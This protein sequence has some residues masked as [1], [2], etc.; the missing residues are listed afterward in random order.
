MYKTFFIVLFVL[1][2]FGFIAVTVIFNQAI[3]G[4]DVTIALFGALASLGAAVFAST[5]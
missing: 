3:T 2:S 1:L 4:T 5:D